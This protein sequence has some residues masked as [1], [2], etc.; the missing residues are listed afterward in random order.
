MPDPSSNGADRINSFALVSY[1]PGVLGTFLDDLR[2]R[3]EPN[4]LCPRSHITI[5]PP[6]ELAPG[7]N[8]DQAWQ[9]LEPKLRAVQPF[10]VELGPPEIFETTNV[11]Y[12]AL[13]QG[14]ADLHRLH[15]HLSNG[16]L[17]CEERFGYHPHVTI[18]Q[19]LSPEQAV[20]IRQLA[21]DIWEHQYR[22]PRGYVV[23]SV[24]FVQNSSRDIWYDLAG[25]SLLDAASAR[26]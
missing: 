14:A 1:I 4:S 24:S 5:L 13:R 23:D 3:L 11:V 16:C 22:G 17:K 20:S 7:V 2:R 6:R 12:F 8:P 21:H 25:F 15:S 10:P 19:R 26:R 9:E 18:A